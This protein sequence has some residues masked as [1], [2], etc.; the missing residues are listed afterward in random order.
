MKGMEENRQHLKFLCKRIVSLADG[1]EGR[2]LVWLI[3][4]AEI[5]FIQ[6]ELCL[7]ACLL[8]NGTSALFRPSELL[9]LAVP[10]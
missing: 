4:P 9:D 8:L 10:P 3:H 7:F 6:P 1:R 5:I 2:R